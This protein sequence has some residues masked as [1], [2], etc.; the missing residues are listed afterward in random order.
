MSFQTYIDTVYQGGDESGIAIHGTP[1][2]N[3]HLLGT[4]RGSHGC[5]RVHPEHAKIIRKFVFSLQ[6]RMVP[7]LKWKEWVS[8]EKQPSPLA[9]EKVS[10]VPVLFVIFNGY[11][12]DRLMNAYNKNWEVNIWQNQASR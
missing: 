4:R 3:H 11:N 9:T 2:R 10:R 12:S 7:K 5:A 8:F 6:E 1:T